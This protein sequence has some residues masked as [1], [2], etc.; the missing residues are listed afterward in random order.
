MT[1]KLF[2]VDITQVLYYTI[3]VIVNDDG[4]SK[5]DLGEKIQ[6]IALDHLDCN[7]ALYDEIAHIQWKEAEDYDK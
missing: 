3:D 1:E 6:C 7:H 4:L 5:D 2:V